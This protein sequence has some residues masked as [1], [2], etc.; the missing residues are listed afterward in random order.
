MTLIPRLAVVTSVLALSLLTLAG[1]GGGEDVTTRS[2]REA[3][4]LWNRANIQDYNLEWTVSGPR[5]GHYLVY[6]RG[7]RVEAVQ[8]ILPDGRTIEAHPGDPRYYSVDGLFRTIEEELDQ[9]EDPHPFGQPEGA[10]V[11]LKFTTDPKLGYP[12]NYQRDVLGSR[13]SLSIDVK[14]L[15][16]NPPPAIPPLHPAPTGSTRTPSRSS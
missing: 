13:Q 10:D 4:Q 12:R 1:C 8:S 15:D 14:S 11:L 6:V 2:L 7:G 16:T 5:Q 9:A 3:R